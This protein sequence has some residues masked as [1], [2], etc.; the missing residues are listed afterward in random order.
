[1]K[2]LYSL[3]ALVTLAIYIVN[4][5]KKRSGLSSLNK[6]K[7]TE[8]LSDFLEECYQLVGRHNNLED[9]SNNQIVS[10]LKNR[11]SKFEFLYEREIDA[12]Q[13]LIATLHKDFEYGGGLAN[14]K[15]VAKDELYY[16]VLKR[17]DSGELFVLST[18]YSDLREKN[19]QTSFNS[20]ILDIAK[21]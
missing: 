13:Y 20:L 7:K 6:L 14:R 15:K 21:G 12:K 18:G 19:I 5:V 11:S 17:Q 2:I 10:R 1:M 4:K 3:F 16:F 9:W 8:D